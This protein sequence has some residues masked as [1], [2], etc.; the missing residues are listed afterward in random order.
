LC[1]QASLQ[2]LVVALPTRAVHTLCAAR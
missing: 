1:V 2:F